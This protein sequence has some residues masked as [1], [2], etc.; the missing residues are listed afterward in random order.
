LNSLNSKTDGMS[1]SY[2]E[3]NLGDKSEILHSMKA[4]RKLKKI[5]GKN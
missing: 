2:T 3:R 1:C 4:G 5:D